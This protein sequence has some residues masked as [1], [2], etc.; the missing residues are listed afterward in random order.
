MGAG[1]LFQKYRGLKVLVADDEQIFHEVL[2]NILTSL[3]FEVYSAYNGQA[4]L[5]LFNEVHPQIIISDIYM[6]KM[7]G[8]IMARAIQK[9]APSIPMIFIT[10]SVSENAIVFSPEMKVIKVLLKPF[11]LYDII[12]ALEKTLLYLEIKDE[13]EAAARFLNA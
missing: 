7:N 11:K 6:P 12:G 4:G 9:I 5:A 2:N 3:G 1:A 8:L 13:P 10:G